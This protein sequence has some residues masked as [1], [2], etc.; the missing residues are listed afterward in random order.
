MATAR[1]RQATGGIDRG[2]GASPAPAYGSQLNYSRRHSVRGDERMIAFDLR[3][4]E[5]VGTLVIA[6]QRL[7]P[8]NA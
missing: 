3:R 7:R 6:L 5:N 8:P 1:D 2:R 4:R